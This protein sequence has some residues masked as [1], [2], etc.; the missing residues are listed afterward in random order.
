MN[1]ITQATCLLVA[2]IASASAGQVAVKAG[3]LH[4]MAG[5]SITDAVVVINEAG[6]ITAVGPEASTPIPNGH[7]VYECA[8]ATPGLVDVRGTVG[9]TGIYN[10][11]HDQDVLETS[12]PIQPELR[13]FDAYNPREPL[14]G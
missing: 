13:A 7:T 4:T 3:T 1:L 5:D 6:A 12:S 11:D 8:V 2:C 10:V 9:L 14:G